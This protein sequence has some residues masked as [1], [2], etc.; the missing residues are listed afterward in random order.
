[1]TF[2][3][4]SVVALYLIN[5]LSEFSVLFPHLK[6]EIL[7]LLQTK[8]AS[9]AY[10]RPW[11]YTTHLGYFIVLGGRVVPLQ[12]VQHILVP[13]DSGRASVM[14]HDSSETLVVEKCRRASCGSLHTHPS[15]PFVRTLCKAG[16]GFRSS[17]SKTPEA[18]VSYRIWDIFSFA[19]PFFFVLLIYPKVYTSCTVEC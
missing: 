10:H 5:K 3:Y 6:N 16:I 2:L 13:E 19:L 15:S 17:V 1:M 18:I 9:L 7:V 8:F 12:D 4:L 14:L 11:A